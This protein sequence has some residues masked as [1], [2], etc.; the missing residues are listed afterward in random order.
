VITVTNAKV[1]G[2]V[3]QWAAFRGFSILFD[4]PGDSLS[5]TN[6]FDLLRPVVHQPIVASSTKSAPALG[7][8]KLPASGSRR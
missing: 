2:F 4:N 6:G 7:S 5:S 8:T 1:G 3:P